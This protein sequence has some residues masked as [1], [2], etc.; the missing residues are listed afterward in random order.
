MPMLCLAGTYR[1][2]GTEPDGDSGRVV[3]R[4][5]AGWDALR[6]LDRGG[7]LPR[8]RVN[9]PGGPQ[10][11]LDGVDALETHYA[12]VGGPS[13]PQP[14][15][16]AH[17]AG[18]E[19]LRWLGFRQVERDGERVTSV[20]EDDRPGFILT[21]TADTYGRCVALVGRGDPP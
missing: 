7:G 15:G 8:F 11:R 16:L 2:T 4:D 21:R 10:L 14:L 3:P 5:P 13:L 18:A 17:E 20:A 19:L 12:P 9:A 6:G 1:I